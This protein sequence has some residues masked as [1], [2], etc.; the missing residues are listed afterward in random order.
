MTLWGKFWLENKKPSLSLAPQLFSLKE[1]FGQAS[2]I[3]GLFWVKLTH[4]RFKFPFS[5]KNKKLSTNFQVNIGTQVP[6]KKRVYPRLKS[7]IFLTR[8]E[9]IVWTTSFR[10]TLWFW[11][12]KLV[13][14]CIYQE[15]HHREKFYQQINVILRCIWQTCYIS[16]KSSSCVF[17]T[18]I[19][20]LLCY[21]DVKLT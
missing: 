17:W 9:N 20:Q 19:W 4:F 21:L 10:G 6:Y 12:I 15:T 13:G 1:T 3:F 8:Y 2:Y 16:F 18:Q 5:T 7:L 11:K 14:Y